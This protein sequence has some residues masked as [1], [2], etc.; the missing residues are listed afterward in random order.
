MFEP[1]TPQSGNDTNRAVLSTAISTKR[2]A[3]TLDK[4]L[5]LL[6]GEKPRRYIG[7]DE[8]FDRPQPLEVG[9]SREGRVTVGYSNRTE[10]GGFTVLGDITDQLK[11]LGLPS[12]DNG[13]AR[14]RKETHEQLE[15][16]FRALASRHYSNVPYPAPAPVTS[17]L[18]DQ[19]DHLTAGLVVATQPPQAP[20][21]PDSYAT[22]FYGL[23]ELLGITGPRQD[24]PI[25]VY[26]REVRPA[27][28]K[29][30]DKE[31][32]MREALTAITEGSQSVFDNYGIAR[33]A[34]VKCE[35]LDKAEIR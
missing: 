23:A 17:A 24:A 28:T 20:V 14:V 11:R 31:R 32:I 3:D 30:I 18:I 26:R 10:A 27:L 9:L 6:S 13:D 4:I 5:A 12:G 2:T 33:A 19:I 22:A 1:N 21:P 25:E 15:R 35:A 34:I 16:L 29:L 7:P 8:A